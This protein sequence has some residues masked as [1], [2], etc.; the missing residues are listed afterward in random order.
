M[1]ATFGS[2]LDFFQYAVK[3]IISRASSSDVSVHFFHKSS[4]AISIP[5]DTLDK[6]YKMIFIW[7]IFLFASLF[8]LCILFCYCIVPFVDCAHLHDFALEKYLRFVI[9][10]AIIERNIRDSSQ[11]V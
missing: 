1:L 7:L 8:P 4:F 10:G 9:T 5:L 2:I 11:R 3:D 6:S